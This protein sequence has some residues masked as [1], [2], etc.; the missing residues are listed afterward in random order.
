[1][2]SGNGWVHN[3]TPPGRVSKQT[4]TLQ[5][6]LHHAVGAQQYAEALVLKL[7]RE[8][9]ELQDAWNVV[10]D[11]QRDAQSAWEAYQ[12]ALAVSRRLPQVRVRLIVAW[13]VLV[14][15]LLL[16][17]LQ[18]TVGSKL[19]VLLVTSLAIW[20]LLSRSRVWLRLRKRPRN[21][22]RLEQDFQRLRDRAERAKAHYQ[23]KLMGNATLRDQLRKAQVRGE[24]W[25]REVLTLQRQMAALHPSPGLPDATFTLTGNLAL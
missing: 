17:D 12:A 22:E 24:S 3:Q 5:Q 8:L 10:R 1:M 18:V 9:G 16:A 20:Y 6:Q 19:T 25:Q 2:S 4:E 13:I 7:K 11:A 21:L 23:F 14:G 15:S